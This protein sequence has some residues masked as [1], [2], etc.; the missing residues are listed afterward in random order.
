MVSAVEK[1]GDPAAKRGLRAAYVRNLRERLFD[2]T[3][4]EKGAMDTRTGLA[5][6]RPALREKG[7]AEF[8]DGDPLYQAG[9]EIFKDEP[10]ALK[11]VKDL[12]AE[13]SGNLKLKTNTGLGQAGANKA[14]R[15][16]ATAGFGR[17]IIWTLGVL[18]P[19][20]T[21]A[22]TISS[23]AID[24]LNPESD[25]A[26]Y[27]EYILSDASNFSKEARKAMK[28]DEDSILTGEMQRY[29]R[30]A[31]IKSGVRGILP[32][33]EEYQ[34]KQEVNKDKKKRSLGEP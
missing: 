8:T 30:K 22:K 33:D 19:M 25:L 23:A 24:A 17:I 32:K 6:D 7:A 21:R 26:K 15:Q 16:E 4:R 27:A 18:N 12:V 28:K 10:E 2:V 1:S 29:L 20:A 31:I 9:L 13:A 3:K 34:A 5:S 11:F 14:S